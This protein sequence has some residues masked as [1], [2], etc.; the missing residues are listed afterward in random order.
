VRDPTQSTIRNVQTKKGNMPYSV[1]LTEC[2]CRSTATN[3]VAQKSAAKTQ[4][5]APGM[6][7]GT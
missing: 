5:I 1:S 4:T 6:D 2:E 7:A 3:T